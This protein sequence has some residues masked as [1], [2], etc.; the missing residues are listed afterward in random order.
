MKL[1]SPLTTYSR[2]GEVIGALDGYRYSLNAIVY[3]IT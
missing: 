1:S 3:K 2:C